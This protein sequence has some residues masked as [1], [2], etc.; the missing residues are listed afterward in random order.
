VRVRAIMKTRIRDRL[1]FQLVL[2]E[3]FSEFMPFTIL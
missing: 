1:P 3:A 2:R